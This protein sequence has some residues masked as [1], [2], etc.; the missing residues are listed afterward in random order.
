MKTE[1]TVRARQQ[2]LL[3][4]LVCHYADA[5]RLGE[6]PD[7]RKVAVV[8]YGS[9]SLCAICKAMKSAG[10][11]VPRKMPG[12]ELAELIEGAR[13]LVRA[14]LVVDD[15]LR[16][17]RLAGASW[18]QLGDALGVTRQAAQQR[19]AAVERDRDRRTN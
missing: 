14:E 18:S 2:A 5:A 3:D 8:T 4:A 1:T 15:A 17:A 11:Q 13:E 12:A 7:C 16:N 6:R 19:L 9:I 10:R